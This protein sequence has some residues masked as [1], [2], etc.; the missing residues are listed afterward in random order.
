MGQ[1]VG[2][3]GSAERPAELPAVL[4]RWAASGAA[5]RGDDEYKAGKP[6]Q[7]AVCVSPSTEFT[8]GALA[9]GAGSAQLSHLG[10]QCVVTETCSFLKIHFA[11][12]LGA[13]RE[14]A[15]RKLVSHLQGS[16]VRLAAIHG[17]EPRDLASTL[18]FVAVRGGAFVAGSLGDGIMGFRVNG[19]AVPL[20]LPQKGEFANETVF[21]TSSRAGALLQVTTGRAPPIDAFIMMSDGAAE[22]LYLRRE[23]SLARAVDVLWRWH[24]RHAPEV[25]AGAL[26]SNLESVLRR[27]TKDDC[28]VVLLTRV[29]RSVEA[30]RSDDDNFKRFFLSPPLPEDASALE[31]TLGWMTGQP[32]PEG[33]RARQLRR[34]KRHLEGLFVPSVIAMNDPASA[35]EETGVGVASG[36]AEHDPSRLPSGAED[37]G[38]PD[39]DSA[40]AGAHAVIQAPAAESAVDIEPVKTPPFPPTEDASSA[41]SRR[42]IA[43]YERVA[44]AEGR[45]VGSSHPAA[46]D[47]TP[48][49]PAV[50][51]PSHALS[52]S[53]F[54]VRERLAGALS[55]L[56]GVFRGWAQDPAPP[57]PSL[58]SEPS[59]PPSPEAGRVPERS[60]STESAEHSSGGDEDGAERVDPIGIRKKRHGGRAK[61]RRSKGGG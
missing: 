27:K 2:V 26:G 52:L 4:A 12:F 33:I 17:C 51:G 56:G 15:R 49:T 54:H 22:S 34:H 10:A 42:A 16:L 36:P 57:H 43:A 28:S 35:L 39:S 46:A 8:C 24:E 3:E 47:P 7:D 6:C 25:V 45:D 48:P 19:R 21:M 5:V 38:T 40:S 18:H 60:P 50:S 20:F 31:A 59:R 37:R 30:L 13:E 32:R 41:S 55:A 29:T 14:A 61:V 11:R 9:D 23:R 53:G 44:A 58:P 1:S